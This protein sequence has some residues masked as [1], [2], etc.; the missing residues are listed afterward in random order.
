M[1]VS[2]KNIRTKIAEL[3]LAVCPSASEVLAYQP[4]K[5]GATPGIYVR[6]M[7]ADRPPLTVR[8]KFTKFQFDILVLVLQSD[9]NATPPW[10]EDKA[11]DLLDDLEAEVCAML[12]TYRVVEGYWDSIDHS[13]PSNIEHFVDEGVPYIIEAIHVVV[14]VQRDA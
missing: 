2:R 9:R 11:E 10:T 12:T 8:G 6:S 3:L 7:S 4:S 5:I 1:A 14:E 13:Q